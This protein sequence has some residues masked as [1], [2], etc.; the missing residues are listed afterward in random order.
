MAMAM[1]RYDKHELT[2]SAFEERKRT[3][4][5]EAAH[6]VAMRAY[7]I[8]IKFAEICTDDP[9]GRA[10]AVVYSTF[11][12]VSYAWADTVATLA[13]P[14]GELAF[15]DDEGG[16]SCDFEQAER[17]ARKVDPAHSNEIM[18]L[19]RAA[20]TKV[21]HN[22]RTAISALAEVLER[23]GKLT[24]AEID[25]IIGKIGPGPVVP[26]MTPIGHAQRDAARRRIRRDYEGAAFIEKWI[27]Q[28]TRSPD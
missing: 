11:A 26:D 4:L 23:E 3:A 8:P 28:Q 15:F 16:S 6:A 19:A 2:Q 17:S 13:G 21:V 1:A 14:Q 27:R 10:G 9:S 24:G 22:N 7:G 18:Q 5:H 25:G 20:A 12:E